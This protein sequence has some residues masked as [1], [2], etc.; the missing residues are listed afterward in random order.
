MPPLALVWGYLPLAGEGSTENAT[1][2][3]ELIV[4]AA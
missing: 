2:V 1:L 4:G 3:T